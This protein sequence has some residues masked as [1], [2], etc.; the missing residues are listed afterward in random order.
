MTVLTPPQG[1]SVDLLSCDGLFLDTRFR[2][3]LGSKLGTRTTWTPCS[4]IFAAD[5]TF[6]SPVAVR[7]LQGW[8]R[9]RARW[10]RSR[11]ATASIADSISGANLERRSGCRRLK[12]QV[13]IGRRFRGNVA[14]KQLCAV[15]IPERREAWASRREV[16]RQRGRALRAGRERVPSGRVPARPVRDSRASAVLDEFV[17]IPVGC[18]EVNVA[19]AI[20]LGWIIDC[21]SGRSE[22]DDRVVEVLYAEPDRTVGV[23]HATWIGDSEMRSVREC[24]QVGLNTADLC[25]PEA[26]DVLNKEGHLSPM[27]RRGSCKHKPEY[28]HER[29]LWH[30]STHARSSRR[31]KPRRRGRGR[32]RNKG[33]VPR[34]ASAAVFAVRRRSGSGGELRGS[35]RTGVVASE[36]ARSMSWRRNSR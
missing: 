35:A 18:S 6:T 10:S 16:L 34:F 26:E 20:V 17:E 33:P 30:L 31:A 32:D 21:N 4:R 9:M 24:V 3:E 23:T 25:A 14:V 13:D 22:L 27:H 36:C 2:P 12:D 19:L 8:C 7:I 28:A 15:G 11:A 5:V 1:M 29:S